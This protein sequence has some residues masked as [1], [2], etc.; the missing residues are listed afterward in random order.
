[1]V[2]PTCCLLCGDTTAAASQLCD[3]CQTAMPSVPH[4]CAQC[5][6]FLQSTTARQCGACLSN[7]PPY[8]KLFALYPYI[9]P[10]TELVVRLKFRHQLACAEALAYQILREVIEKWYK[11]QM[12]PDVIVA[13]PLHIHRLKER[14]FNQSLEIAKPLAKKLCIPL[15]ARGLVRVKQT[16]A[17]SGLSARA[18]KQN[19]LDAFITAGDYTGKRLALV[20]D[21]VT[22]GHTVHAC[23]KAL[24]A[25]GAQEIHVWCCARRG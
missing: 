1:M 18:R 17:Q 8:E 14:G 23:C 22:T 3:L 9:T 15:H 20:D 19:L 16:L 6:K 10:V 5:G 13:V 7:P 2:L 4:C 24:K 25:A 11:N 12:L 21:V